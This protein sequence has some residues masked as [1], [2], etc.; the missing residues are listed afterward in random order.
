MTAERLANCKCEAKLMNSNGD[1]ASANE[2][3]QHWLTEANR[4]SE[5][6]PG[7]P[8][9]SPRTDFGRTSREERMAGCRKSYRASESHSPG[10]FTE[11]CYWKYPKLV[12]LSV[13]SECEGVSTAI[14]V[15]P[16]RFKNLPRFCYNDDAF[17]MV[18]SIAIQLPSI[19]GKYLVVCD[20]FHYKNSVFFVEKSDKSVDRR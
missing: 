15:L 4:T 6:F 13:I 19:N 9:V 5:F 10:I 20:R 16:P 3:V 14:S 17:N 8:K 1:L 12:G 18:L 7:K 2:A 11:Q